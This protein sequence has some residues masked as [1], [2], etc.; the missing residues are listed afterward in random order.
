MDVVIRYGEVT[1]K[2]CVPYC[3]PKNGGGGGWCA[4]MPIQ[5]EMF[6]TWKTADGLK[7][8]ATVLVKEKLVSPN[9]FKSLML[10]FDKDHLTV[11]QTL[12]QEQSGAVGFEKSPLYQN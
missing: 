11:L 8:E 1:Q 12:E 10:Y 7:H 9:R 4:P 2:F 6:V 5:N 3:V